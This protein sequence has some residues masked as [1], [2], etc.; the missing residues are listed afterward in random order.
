M[1]LRPDTLYVS[2]WPSGGES[3]LLELREACTGECCA[4][5]SSREELDLKMASMGLATDW[6]DWTRAPARY[7]T[8]SPVRYSIYT[9]RS[10]T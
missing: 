3:P 1:Q 10:L 5:A 2:E 9:V 8:R 7:W 4:T 6:T